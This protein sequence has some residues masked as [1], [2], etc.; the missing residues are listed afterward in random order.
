MF[1]KSRPM[2]FGD[3][4]A[5]IESGVGGIVKCEDGC[6]G[7]KARVAPELCNEMV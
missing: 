2:F 3:S 4:P 1:S 5:G 6:R 7:S